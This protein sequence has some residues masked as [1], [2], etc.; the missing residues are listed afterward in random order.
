MRIN[1]NKKHYTKAERILGRVLQ[2]NKIPFKT[3]QKLN[4]KEIDFLIGNLAIEV[5]GHTQ[6]ESKNE[7][8]IKL[9]YLPIHFLNQEI[10]LNREKVVEIIRNKLSGYNKI[11]ITKG[12][13]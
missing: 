8:L 5:D 9:G 1:L 10:S 6:V 3:K 12:I 2:E 4:N 11:K 7:D 13:D